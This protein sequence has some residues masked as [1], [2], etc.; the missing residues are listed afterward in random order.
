VR[1]NGDVTPCSAL[2]L[3]ENVVGNVR[4]TGGLAR[5]L[6][7]ERCRENL[8]WCHDRN[9]QGT[10]ASCPH[11]QVCHGGCPDILLTMCR[12]R[13]ENEYCHHRVEMHSILDVLMDAP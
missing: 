4:E 8:A 10:C 13:Y 9:L 1:A 11:A 2:A 6:E 7:E 3:P 5:I 12:N